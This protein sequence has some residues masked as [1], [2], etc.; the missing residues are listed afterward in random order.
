V[1]SCRKYADLLNFSLSSETK[2]FVQLKPFK[3]CEVAT[4]TYRYLNFQSFLV[5]TALIKVSRTFKLCVR[6]NV[7]YAQ[8]ISF[9]VQI[10]LMML[11]AFKKNDVFLEYTHTEVD[12]EKC[13]SAPF[14]W[15]IQFSS[16]FSSF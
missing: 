3:A 2:I 12:S 16:Q 6:F 14:E 4:V 7:S 13:L 5:I 8:L 1:K 10:H 15:K 9:T 11:F